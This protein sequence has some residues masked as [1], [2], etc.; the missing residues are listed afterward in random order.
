MKN[1]KIPAGL[2]CV[3]L[4]MLLA[5]FG[6]SNSRGQI[7][8][9]SN[10]DT[11]TVPSNP[12]TYLNCAAIDYSPLCGGSCG[13]AQ[14]TAWVISDDPTGSPSNGVL[15]LSDGGA[16]AIALYFTGLTAD[17][18]VTNSLVNP[19]DYMVGVVY[20]L[21][22]G[23]GFEIYL[24]VYEIQNVGTGSL[25][26]ATGFP[27]T[28]TMSNGFGS[29]N[30]Y[31]HIDAMPEYSTI[32]SGTYP[33]VNNVV[34]AF[35]DVNT[36]VPHPGNCV[37]TANL[38]WQQGVNLIPLSLDGAVFLRNNSTTPPAFGGSP[39]ASWG[40][41]LMS[42]YTNNSYT[43]GLNS[44]TDVS[45]T[46]N[47]TG[48]GLDYRAFYTFTDNAGNLRI[49]RYNFTTPANISLSAPT[50][51]SWGKFPRVESFK[52]YNQ[53]LVIPSVALYDVVD[54]WTGTGEIFGYASTGSGINYTC[55]LGS[56]PWNQY[57]VV[58]GCFGDI[59]S[60]F[61]TVGYDHTDGTNHTYLTKPADVSAN[62]TSPGVFYEVEQNTPIS[63]TSS[64]FEGLAVTINNDGLNGVSNI[65]YIFSVWSNNNFVVKK[66]EPSQYNWK[67]SHTS[68]VEAINISKEWRIAPNPCKINAT[69]YSPLGGAK[70][71]SFE[72]WDITGRIL[73]RGTV[74]GNKQDLDLSNFASGVYM[75]HLYENDKSVKTIKLVRE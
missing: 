71:A 28:Y 4:T 59:T 9:A 34:V 45:V 35:N 57:P 74:A 68:S 16:P 3:L 12:L 44:Y 37:A 51:T 69:I 31:P 40:G 23:C 29:A 43:L 72:I 61:Y 26:V 15:F 5:T 18:V 66:S 17:V 49:E 11:A 50:G 27:R 21:Y 62:P 56:T 58:A 25:T 2:Q 19:G 20:A 55:Y 22:S 30:A 46:E 42:P 7:I 24:D 33:P 52:D 73:Q 38:N 10:T 32:G 60:T 54:D 64:F 67:H 39:T 13:A 6:I 65:P 48:V 14:L 75:I 41:N 36:Y 63:S 70:S 53:Q 1:I 47:N 8:P